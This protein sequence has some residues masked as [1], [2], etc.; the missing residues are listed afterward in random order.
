MTKEEFEKSYAEKS[1]MTVEELRE[2][3]VTIEPCDCEDELCHG[4]QAVTQRNKEE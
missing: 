4:W 2:L 1:N 3:G